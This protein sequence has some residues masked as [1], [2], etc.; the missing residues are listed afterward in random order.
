MKHLCGFVGMVIGC[1]VLVWLATATF[2]Q[3]PL[4][5]KAKIEAG[6]TVYST[7]CAPCHGDQLVSTGQFPN[8]RRLTPSDRAKFASTVR[9]GRNQMPPWRGALSDEQIDQIWAYIRS[10]ADR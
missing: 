4:P 7:Y 2:A 3:E 1:G 10:I 8:L 6:E 5:D 9:D